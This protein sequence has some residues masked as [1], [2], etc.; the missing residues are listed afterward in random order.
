MHSASVFPVTLRSELAV[1]FSDTSV[2]ELATTD[3]TDDLVSVQPVPPDLH[4][5]VALADVIAPTPCSDD[6]FRCAVG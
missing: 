4:E 1:G 2:A 6:M 3:L 5:A